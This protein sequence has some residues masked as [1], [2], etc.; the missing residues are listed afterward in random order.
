LLSHFIK[1]FNYDYPQINLVNVDRSDDGMLGFLYQM[2]FKLY[3]SQYE[4]ELEL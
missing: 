4:M 3:T 1:N 2:G